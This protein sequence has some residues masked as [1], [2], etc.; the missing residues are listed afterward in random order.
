MPPKKKSAAAAKA[1]KQE[2]LKEIGPEPEISP[3][4]PKK[5]PKKPFFRHVIYNCSTKVQHIR[6]KLWKIR[7]CTFAE[8]EESEHTDLDV[9]FDAIKS[10]LQKK[11][12]NTLK[13][14]IIKKSFKHVKRIDSNPSFLAKFRFTKRLCS[15]L[16]SVE[17]KFK[18]YRILR[19]FLSPSLKNCYLRLNNEEKR[20]DPKLVAAFRIVRKCKLVIDSDANEIYMRINPAKLISH[21]SLNE[22]FPVQDI[23]DS[24]YD[25]VRNQIIINAT[26][27]FEEIWYHYPSVPTRGTKINPDLSFL[28]NLQ[29]LHLG[30]WSKRPL[31]EKMDDLSF[32]KQYSRLKTLGILLQNREI[33]TLDYVADLPELKEF[34]FGSGEPSIL[35]GPMASLPNLT[36]LEKFELYL[37]DP[38]IFSMEH[39]KDFIFQNKGLKELDL[40]L[41]IQNI[42]IL[43][44]EDEDFT[45]PEIEKLRL[46]LINFE[47]PYAGAA[48][49]I[50][51]VLK[52][53]DSIKEVA[54]IVDQ[55]H[56]DLNTIL[57][58]DGLAKM[59]S[60][61]KL[62]LE[63]R[64]SGGL[65]ENKYKHLKDVFT[66]QTGLVALDLDISCDA[67]ASRELGTILDGL[68]K[69]KN[70][71]KFRLKAML[72]KMTPAAF[73]KLSSFIVSL[74]YI[75]ALE[76]DL[77]GL[78][79]EDG[80][81]L[82][83]KMLPKAP[84]SD[85]PFSF[86]SSDR[87]K[88]YKNK[89]IN[90]DELDLE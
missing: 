5:I 8:Y 77:R 9:P 40:S 51:E 44:A 82:R 47:R 76:F 89:N 24:G 81:Q 66:N 75:K 11:F 48:K 38:P 88:Y 32:V 10:I 28:P 42:G 79:E 64:M 57:L 39:V 49:R 68:M 65:E 80:E 37:N 55:S 87:A 70:L 54:L 19:P 43:F 23:D 36:Q 34:K 22:L 20:I 59:K 13:S 7:S 69:L 58:K 60:L 67:I 14:S 86:Y 26:E 33:Q 85:E 56:A 4:E 1:P 12:Q 83:Q 35:K 2:P 73:N 78:S 62:T 29:E 3:P 72:T 45:L 52:T 84:L 50:T 31:G 90:E 27:C 74:R 30:C 21:R 46:N 15:I 61:E 63:F 25:L 18:D 41:T 6:A 71:K 17:E 16:L 53:H